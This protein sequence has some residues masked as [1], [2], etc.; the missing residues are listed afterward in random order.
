MSTESAPAKQEPRPRSGSVKPVGRLAQPARPAARR[1][2][3]P[4]VPGGQLFQLAKNL[5][6]LQAHDLVTEGLPVVTARE[7][8]ASFHI[9]DRDSVLRAVGISERTLQRGKAA[10]K[11]LDSNASDRVLRLASVTEQAIDVLGSQEAAE[12]WLATPAL[13]LDERKPIDLLQSSEGT[14]LVRTL[15]TRMDYGVYA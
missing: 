7:L 4:L 10:D 14:E 8:M 9:V 15:L 5:S 1:L 11:L 13:G 6:P 2:A 3:A 12:R